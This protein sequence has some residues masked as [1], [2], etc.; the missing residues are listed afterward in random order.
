MPSCINI[1]K[2][3]LH[4]ISVVITVKNCIMA[5]SSSLLGICTA[6]K[7]GTRVF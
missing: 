5:C 7:Q 3:D 6:K 2:S 4:M 1:Q